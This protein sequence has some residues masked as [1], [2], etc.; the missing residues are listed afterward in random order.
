VPHAGVLLISLRPGSGWDDKQ[1]QILTLE[2]EDWVREIA[3]NWNSFIFIQNTNFT[4]VDSE[5][6]VIWSGGEII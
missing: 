6:K 1:F 3:K 2:D 4:E 5:P